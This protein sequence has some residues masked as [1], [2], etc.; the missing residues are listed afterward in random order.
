MKMR[1][2][3]SIISGAVG[4][5]TLLWLT[6]YAA[7]SKATDFDEVR[8][9][10]KDTNRYVRSLSPED[11]SPRGQSPLGINTQGTDVREAKRPRIFIAD[12]VVNNTDPNLTNTDVANDGETSIAVNPRDQKEIVISAFSGSWGANAPIYHALDG[13]RTWTREF[14]IP[15]PPG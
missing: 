14:S 6:T 9:V 4:V 7:E 3:F 12:V 8:S 15:I 2:T 13:G 11:M 5:A 10:P 1:S